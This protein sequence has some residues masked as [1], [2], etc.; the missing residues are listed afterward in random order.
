MATQQHQQ[1]RYRS[2]SSGPGE[3]ESQSSSKS[4]KT[5]HGQSA[6]PTRVRRAARGKSQPSSR[7]LTPACDRCRAS[8]LRCQAPDSS[9]SEKRCAHCVRTDV[10]CKYT[11]PL[12][13]QAASSLNRAASR[14][15]DAPDG[16]ERLSKLEANVVKLLEIM[17]KKTTPPLPAEST[18]AAVGRHGESWH[19][20]S[21]GPSVQRPAMASYPS[22]QTCTLEELSHLATHDSAPAASSGDFDAWLSPSIETTTAPRDPGFGNLFD[23]LVTAATDHAEM[24][25]PSPQP[26][27]VMHHRLS[28]TTTAAS[29]SPVNS[30]ETKRTPASVHDSHHPSSGGA[31]QARPIPKA[32]AG[33]RMAAFTEPLSHE[34]P[35]RPLAYNP[36]TF[37]NTEMVDEGNGE[38]SIVG[39]G[40]STPKRGRGDPIDRGIFQEDEARSLFAL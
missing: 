28:S 27:A 20:S 18:S 17:E 35:F 22:T 33:S 25:L 8:K 16:N 23:T 12:P 39:G 10:D 38:L 14:A 36:D 34:A 32:G 13:P 15:P 11:N 26:P 2:A 1:Q 19:E 5:H 3:E 31:A 37:R 4:L 40:Q 30:V 6:P 7:G 24:P 9:S 29:V 21:G